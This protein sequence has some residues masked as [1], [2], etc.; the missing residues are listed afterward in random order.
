M[1]EQIQ[2][3]EELRVIKQYLFMHE[4]IQI[5]EELRVYKLFWFFALKVEKNVLGV[6][7]VCFFQIK[8]AKMWK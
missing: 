7:F 4:Q 1:H 6:K 8:F 5:Q 2:I 3:E